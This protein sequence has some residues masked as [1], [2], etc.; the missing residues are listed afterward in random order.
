MNNYTDIQIIECNRLHSEE[1][2][3]NNNENTSLWQNNLQDIVHLEPGDKV[4]VYGSFISERGAGQSQTVEVKG[5]ELGKN[6]E[7]ITT[8]I[9]GTNQTDPTKWTQDNPQYHLPSGFGRIDAGDVNKKIQVRDDTLNIVINYYIPSNAMNCL[10]LPRNW[11]A[12]APSVRENFFFIDSDGTQG[13][14]RTKYNLA[15]QSAYNFWLKNDFYRV[16]GTTPPSG[17]DPGAFKPLNDNQ[18]YTLMIR[19]KTSY[20]EINAEHTQVADLDLRDPENAIYTTYKELK[21]IKIPPGFNSAEFIADEIT[22][23]LQEITKDEI[24]VQD[25]TGNDDYPMNVARILESETY[26][27]F[28]AGNVQ[29]MTKENFKKYFSL[30]TDTGGDYIPGTTNGSGFEWLR[31]YQIIACKYPEI[32]EKGRL[33]NTNL[34]GENQGIGGGFVNSAWNGNAGVGIEI[35]AEYTKDNL[36]IWKDFFQAQGLYPD[37]FESMN[38]Q[39]TGYDSGYSV[40]NTRFCHINRWRYQ[41]QSLA[42]VPLVLNTQLGWGGYYLPRSYS[43]PVDSRQL[44]SFLLPLHFDPNQEDT[45]YEDPVVTNGQFTYGAFSKSAGGKILIHPTYHSN[46]VNAS[47]KIKGEL[48]TNG[49]S[50]VEINRKIGFDLHFNAPGMYY[51]LPLSGWSNNPNPTSSVAPFIGNWLVP[52]NKRDGKITGGTRYDMSYWHKKL[53]I[54]ADRP[55]LNWDGTHF[56]FSGFHTALNRG[57]NHLAG[58][59]LFNS[60]TS[61]ADPAP[62]EDPDAGDVVYKINPVELF[63]D[64]TPDRTPYL[65]SVS[66]LSYTTFGLDDKYKFNRINDNYQKQLP[67]DQLSGILVD[68]YGIDETEW[69]DSLWGLLGFSYEQFHDTS[70][71]RLTRVQSGNVAKLS[72]LTTNSEI[73][74]GDTKIMATNYV[75]TPLYNGMVSTPVSIRDYNASPPPEARPTVKA[76]YALFPPII[77]KTQSMNIQAVNLPTRMIRGYYTI[78]SNILENTPFIGGKVNNTDM[79]IIGIVDKING[80]GDFYFGQ[81][82]SLTFTITKPLR[83][84]SLTIGIHDPDG[85]YSRTSE[86]ST[87]LF[88][89]E[90]PVEATFNVIQEILEENKKQGELILQKMNPQN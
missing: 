66:L 11:M 16:P 36:K 1:A 18:R 2:K 59:P 41:D 71:N 24:Q 32:Y 65:D 22:R 79:P 64:F 52:D 67:Y 86:Q 88:K 68:D 70:A 51:L 58:N 60:G 31:Q 25:D 17:T 44:C 26:K 72:Y 33:V 82:G 76:Q 19:D 27:A 37:I 14:T 55:S 90:K 5:V 53:Y 47:T 61:A 46:W 29:D 83:L 30:S 49:A 38:G 12:N 8:N 34:F 39:D 13:R 62:A 43:V 50:S 23:Q 28:N 3:A 42:E 20:T 48:F 21:E 89:I 10:H 6:R 84:A 80:D 4:S 56:G 73:V 69:E 77:H 45:Y 40:S 87:I 9:S 15:N 63:C 74:E 75:G 7:F 85:S 35:L 54:G 57:N 78:R 81:E